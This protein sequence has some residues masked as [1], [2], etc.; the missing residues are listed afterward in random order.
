M[1]LKI[2]LGFG[3]LVI[4]GIAG[5]FSFFNNT[6]LADTDITIPA[7][8]S[9]SDKQ[10]YMKSWQDVLNAKDHGK[11]DSG[12]YNDIGIIRSGLKDYDGAIR[13]F[14]KALSL[15]SDDPRFKRNL[16]TTYVDLSDYVNAEK[17]FK[18]VFADRPTQPEYWLDLVDL[19][20]YQL[21]DN[22]KAKAF[23]EEAL[24]KSG[25][26]LEVVKSYAVFSMDV[27]KDYSTSLKYWQMLAERD[28]D[29]TH[30]LDYQTTIANLKLK[31]GRFE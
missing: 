19:Y 20:R 2:I 25:E 22:S 3:V 12:L 31:S 14:K 1:K 28:T 18:E 27:L 11:N 16:A 23:F 30:K 8:L 10:F 7:D 13:A 21:K 9:E 4:V 29:P 26:H 17:W 5:Y 6:V 24:I 15:N